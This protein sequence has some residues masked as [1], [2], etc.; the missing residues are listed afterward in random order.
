MYQ[1]HSQRT[2]QVTT[3]HL[4]Q[5]MMLLSLTNE[6]LKQ[7]IDNE[8]ASNPA[9]ELVEER[10]CPTCHRNLQNHKGPCPVCSKPKDDLSL[11][12]VVFLSPAEDFYYS[13]TNDAEEMTDDP[14][15]SQ[16]DELPVYVMRQVGPELDAME[17]KWA[18]FILT[19][20]DEDGLLTIQSD[21]VARYYHVPIERIDKVIRV[22]QRADP[23][24][25][26][27]GS[28]KEA[29]LV[30]LDVLSESKQV[31]PLAKVIVNDHLDYLSRHLYVELGRK[32][33]VPASHV[34]AIAQFVTENLNPFPARS[35]WGD[36]R[37]PAKSV[38]Q[39]FHRPDVIISYLNDDATKPL[40]VEIVMP[41]FGMLRVN[42][43]FKQVVHEAEAEKKE[44]WKNDL[45]RASLFVKCLQQRNH[46]MQ[47]LLYRVVLEQ[48]GYI[49]NGEEWLKPM[50]RAQIARELEVHESTI[51]RAVANKTVQLPN[52]RI[53]SLASFFDRS[54]N[55]RTVLKVVIEQENYPLSDTELV[56]CL[57]KRGYFVAR[58]TVAKY[59]KME[60]ILPAHLR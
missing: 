55:V 43:L 24:G 26:G 28:P 20:L 35:H 39:V 15:P 6:E 53:I 38:V 12:P 60:G 59:R 47:R 30:Q 13:G 3:A 33:K 48:R 22:I 51:S 41:L 18:A 52:K 49:L 11:E 31:P 45:D 36:M 4:T 34:R 16:A 42:P 10:F 44:D 9:L 58:R 19:H 56:E 29:M 57:A 32:L 50:T 2:H 25:V 40:A 46:T 54:L 37:Q 14:S 8:L 7:Q 1:V 23:I 5:T 17:R 27:S 21:E